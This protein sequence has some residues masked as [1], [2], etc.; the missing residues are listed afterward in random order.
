[1]PGFRNSAVRR[2]PLDLTS[3]IKRASPA[4]TFCLKRN[5]FIPLSFI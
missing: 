2:G 4:G 3:A 5:I 1:M